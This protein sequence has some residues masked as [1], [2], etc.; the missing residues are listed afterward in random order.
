MLM[1]CEEDI[2][3]TVEESDVNAFLRKFL[4]R[5]EFQM[6]NMPMYE[7]S[8]KLWILGNSMLNIVIKLS[9]FLYSLV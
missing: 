4:N 3:Y 1:F 7:T 6:L 2:Y 9:T 8:I 5:I